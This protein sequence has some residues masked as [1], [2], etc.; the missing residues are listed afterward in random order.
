MRRLAT[1]ILTAALLVGCGGPEKQSTTAGGGDFDAR[2]A[3]ADLEAQVRIGPR[4]AGSPAAERTARWIEHRLRAAG[5]SKVEVQR[6]YANVV[7]TVEGST[8][9]VVVVGA[10]YDTKDAIPGFVG[11]NDGASGVAVLLEL[12]RALPR[13][14][15]GPSAKLVAFDAE[16]ARGDR[17]F[18]R[19]GSRGS[20]Q[21]VDYA[22]EGG[23]HGSPPLDGVRAMILFD[24]VG[25][26]D[27]RIPLESYSDRDLYDAF[28]VAA[29]DLT[30]SSAPFEGRTGPILDDHVPFRVVG[31]PSVD[32]I[33][34]DY[35]PGPAPGAWWHTPEDTLEHVCAASLDAVGEAAL[36]AIPKLR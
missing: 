20:R 22:R 30:G 26:C 28:A 19:D 18:E 4:P 15:P 32:L 7:G 35:G 5:A 33:D 25:D 2:R 10:H 6:P 13:P 23:G 16:E 9:G 17:P 27:L 36:R 12:A 29:S 34:F 8:S 11:A 31:V 24:M 21:F 14:L 3:F 1:A